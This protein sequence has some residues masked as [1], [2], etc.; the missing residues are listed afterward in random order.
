LAI[1]GASF[2][3][4]AV[5]FIVPLLLVSCG[6]APR[7]ATS[8]AAGATKEV[9]GPGFRFEVP[10]GWRVS[11]SAASV[12]AQTRGALVS[13]T[14]YRLA[15]PYTPDRFAAASAELDRVADRLARAAGGRVKQR[16]TTT[17]AGRRIRAYRFSARGASDRVGFALAGKREVQLLCQAPAGGGDPDAACALL[18]SSFS[19]R[20]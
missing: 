8:P 14:V 7:P 15:K 19:L 2:R 16:E 1:F 11:R 6:S 17:V 4:L 5:L 18:F 13:A 10:S 12:T 3:S 20:G 9:A